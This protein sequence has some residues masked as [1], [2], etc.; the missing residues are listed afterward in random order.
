MNTNRK[1]NICYHITRKMK[2]LLCPI[3]NDRRQ[4]QN[5]KLLT[6]QN[7][8]RWRVNVSSL[9]SSQ[10]HQ[11]LTTWIVYVW[12]RDLFLDLNKVPKLWNIFASHISSLYRQ[13]YSKICCT[14]STEMRLRIWIP[15]GIA[16][17]K[18]VQVPKEKTHRL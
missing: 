1:Q 9:F 16:E 2:F 3:G 7:K 11:H 17:V 6:Q 5:K 8:W 15:S 10:N 14:E 18:T 4:L 13:G 12:R